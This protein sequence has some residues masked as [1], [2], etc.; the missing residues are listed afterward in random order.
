MEETLRATPRPER[1]FLLHSYGGPAEMVPSFVRLGA[2]FS[3]SPY[4]LHERKARQWTTFAQ[5]PLERLLIETD[6]PD[7]W[8]PTEINPHPLRDQDGKEINHPANIE[9]M[10]QA[11]ATLRGM[12]L[13][14]F[15]AVVQANFQRLFGGE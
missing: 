4:F 7:M 2:Y 3:V 5:V 6:A 14:D 13:E 1:G 8:P 11:V 12:S 15:A 9:L 10:Y